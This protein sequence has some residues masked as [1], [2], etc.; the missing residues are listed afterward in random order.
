MVSASLLIQHYLH[1]HHGFFLV[2]YHCQLCSF[3]PLLTKIHHFLIVKLD[4]KNY[5]IWKFQFMPLLKGYALQGYVDGS[6][7]CPSLSSLPLILPLIWHTQLGL[8]K[9]NH[10]LN[11][12]LLRLLDLKHPAIYGLLC[13]AIFPRGIGLGSCNFVE[14]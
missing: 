3:Y 8:S 6:L 1:Q 2:Q 5:L 12:F 7:P 10:L 4:S 13:N 14:S 11:L 9:I